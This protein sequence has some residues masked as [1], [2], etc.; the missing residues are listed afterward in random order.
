M[1]LGVYTGYPDQLSMAGLELYYDASNSMVTFEPL[2]TINHSLQVETRLTPPPPNLNTSLHHEK[3]TNGQEADPD[4][5][6]T[7]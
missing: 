1:A 4:R 5:A 6:N 7:A 3:G 2:S